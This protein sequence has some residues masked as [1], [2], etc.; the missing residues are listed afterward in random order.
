MFAAP[1]KPKAPPIKT[2]GI[3]TKL[4]P[5][6]AGHIEW[7]WRG[8]WV[9]PFLGSGAVLLNIRPPRAL[10]ADSCV[11][12]VNFYQAVQNGQINAG[13]VE[14]FLRCEGE[15][16]RV[17]GADR[18]Y[19]IRERFNNEGDPLDFLFVSRACFNGLVRF[20]QKGQFNTPFCKKPERFRPAYVTKICNQ[21]QWAA[22]TMRGRDWEFV[23]A[24]WRDIV[25]VAEE[26]DFIYADPP[27]SGR[28][29][30]FYNS[31][32]EQDGYELA[33]AL[34]G[35]PCRFLYSMWVENRFRRNDRLFDW[36][37]G[38]EI[39]TFSHYYHLGATES[40]RHAMQEGLVV[41]F[42]DEIASCA[43]CSP[44]GRDKRH[45]M[46]DPFGTNPFC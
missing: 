18:Y 22:D 5:F 15:R 39:A 41:G 12:I 6:I 1:L 25:G 26:R 30:D 13:R 34:K 16:L 38:Y 17:E 27:Y 35:A 23:C 19:Q 21:V 4:T 45:K 44:R 36:F 10:V 11:P 46:L 29:T 32:S 3:K 37:A 31:W 8:R 14:G 24:D 40:L 42:G 20:N 43:T 33:Q 9:E 28:F 2:Q 7:D